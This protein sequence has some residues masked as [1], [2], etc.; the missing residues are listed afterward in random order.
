MKGILSEVIYYNMYLNDSRMQV[1]TYYV[2]C[3]A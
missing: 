2:T 3:C 1:T